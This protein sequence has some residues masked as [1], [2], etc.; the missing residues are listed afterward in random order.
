[1]KNWR[2]N[3]TL[4]EH[5][6]RSSSYIPED[7]EVIKRVLG[8]NFDPRGLRDLTRDYKKGPIGDLDSAEDED[9][10]FAAIEA[11]ISYESGNTDVMS[12]EDYLD[13]LE[14]DPVGMSGSDN[15][16]F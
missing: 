9:L 15:Y 5:E 1:M 4:R 3:N 2:D 11:M 7:I 12:K 13:L 16:Y 8:K 14:I 6:D 10:I